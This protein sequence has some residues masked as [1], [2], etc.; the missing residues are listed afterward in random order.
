[1][2]EVALALPFARGMVAAFNPCGFA[3]LPAYLSYF[4]GLEDAD[5]DTNT[6]R[7]VVRGAV[8][9]LALAAGF[10][11]VF[12]LA[13]LAFKLIIPGRWLEELGWFAIVTGVLMVP[14]GIAMF[15][16]FEP[17]VK[18]PRLNLGTGSRQTASVFLFGVSYAVVSLGC[19]L[20][21]FIPTVID[22]FT[23]DGIVDG[24][25]VFIAYSLGMSLIVVSLTMG[26]AL[27]RNSIAT[28]M[29]RILPYVNKTSGVLLV[30]AGVYLVSFGWDELKTFDDPTS[31]ETS[32]FQKLAEDFE[33]HLNAWVQSVGA[34]RIGWALAVL[35]AGAL[36]LGIAGIDRRRSTTQRPHLRLPRPL[37]SAR[38]GVVPGRPAGHS[39]RPLRRRHPDAGR[40]LV[41]R[42]GPLGGPARDRPVR[43]HH[44]GR[45]AGGAPPAATGAGTGHRRS[46]DP[47]PR[48]DR[49]STTCSLRPASAR[50][51]AWGRRSA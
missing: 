42:P 45:V 9:G 46:P 18:L 40:A 33:N 11:F 15:R 24:L 14:L 2:I 38:A 34:T 7:N 12:L 48:V 5:A 35:I 21:L 39:G 25:A 30:L 26:I 47:R 28:S 37:R 16:G 4:L 3:M 36:V 17:V 27:A 19:T 29:R 41:H 43:R 44:R 23:D 49:C 1:M 51:C 22:S 10:F 50:S 13:G 31:A 20:S 8:V 6:G 32:R